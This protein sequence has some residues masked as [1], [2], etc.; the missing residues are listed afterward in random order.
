M[1]TVSRVGFLR[2]LGAWSRGRRGLEFKQ[3][4]MRARSGYGERDMVRGRRRT[5]RTT[6]TWTLAW[7]RGTSTVTRATDVGEGGSEDVDEG[8]ESRERGVGEGE[9][10]N[11]RI[12]IQCGGW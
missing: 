5:S 7:G 6:R 10:G 1:N 9:Q 12:E 8:E 2:T 3:R 11:V 4:V